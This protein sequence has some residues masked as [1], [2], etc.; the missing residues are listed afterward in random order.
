MVTAAGTD[1]QSYLA[2][3]QQSVGEAGVT[4]ADEK[5]H[6]WTA[7]EVGSLIQDIKAVLKQSTS[8]SIHDHFVCDQDAFFNAGRR[9]QGM[10]HS[11]VFFWLCFN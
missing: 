9:M 1:V 11:C 5:L 7:A 2:D 4:V 10:L 3:L 6:E 8:P